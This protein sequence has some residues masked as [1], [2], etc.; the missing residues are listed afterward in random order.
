MFALGWVKEA[1]GGNMTILVTGGAGYIGSHCVKQLMAE[2]R[3]VVI[4]DNL[5][6]GFRELALSPHFIEGATH[7]EA[8][9][10]TVFNQYDITA[11]MHFAASCY[12][13]ESVLH[14]DGY[15]WNNVAG[16][17]SLLRVMKR[18]G[19]KPFI[20][21]SSC[22]TY[23]VPEVLPIT[24]DTPQAPVN[25]Y[26][27]TKRMVEAILKDYALVGDLDYVSFR[28]FNAAGADP[29][30][31]IG[32]CHE[33]ET[34]LIPLVLQ[35]ASGRKGPV[36]ILGTDYPTPDGTCIRDY[37]HVSDIARAH[38]LGLAYLE[39]GG[40]STSL[41]LGTGL[42]YSVREIIR[43]GEKVTGKSIACHEAARRPGDPP[44]LV[45]RA[46]KAKEVLGW[47]P[48]FQDLPFILNTA[49]QWEQHRAPVCGS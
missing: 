37:V 14:P 38:L 25:P 42:G 24:E 26:G 17:L 43:A 9:L 11:V 10:E 28:Y 1:F 35:S 34:H 22:A 21:S 33:P 18:F 6:T 23:G 16:T 48:Q 27:W 36:D 39:S 29:D 8:L 47:T 3:A 13:G 2:G 45:A 20:F 40:A 30:G 19:V 31:G 4:L 46:D 5:V 41:N 15:Y 7:D 32:E 12:V 44:V 49:W